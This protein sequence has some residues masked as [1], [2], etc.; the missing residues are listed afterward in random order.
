MRYFCFPI[1]PFCGFVSVIFLNK[2]LPWISPGKTP[3]KKGVKVK[4]LTV[5]GS[6]SLQ[7]NLQASCR[8]LH[9]VDFG[10]IPLVQFVQIVGAHTVESVSVGTS[11][12][13]PSSTYLPRKRIPSCCSRVV[14][15]SRYY[16]TDNWQESGLRSKVLQSWEFRFR[17]QE[18]FSACPSGNRQPRT[19]IRVRFIRKVSLWFLFPWSTFWKVSCLISEFKLRIH[20][21]HA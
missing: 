7:A 1:L 2:F 12:Q 21:V 11:A 8:H 3:S 20:S 10:C 17:K 16:E 14:I 15:S 19:R 5:M 13:Q 18:E 6:K 9:C 4:F